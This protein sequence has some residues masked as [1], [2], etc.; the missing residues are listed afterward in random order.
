MMYSTRAAIAILTGLFLLVSCS[1]SQIPAVNVTA[2]GI[3]IK[4]YDPVAY[5]TQGK[6]VQGKKEFSHQWNSATW[7]FGNKMHLELFKGDP[8]RYAPQYGGY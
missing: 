8:A 7:L 5:F 2:D 1:S 3:A 4:G 6:P